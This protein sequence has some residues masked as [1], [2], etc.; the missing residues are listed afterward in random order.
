MAKENLI[1]FTLNENQKKEKWELRR[2]KSHE[3]IKSFEITINNNG[4]ITTNF[5]IIISTNQCRQ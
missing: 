1:K 4:D 3:I 2:D 5:Y